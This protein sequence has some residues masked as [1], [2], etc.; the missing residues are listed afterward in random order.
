MAISLQQTLADHEIR[1]RGIEQR[2]AVFDLIIEDHAELEARVIAIE[3]R[4][5]LRTSNPNDNWTPETV[6]AVRPTP[7]PNAAQAFIEDVAARRAARRNPMAPHR[8]VD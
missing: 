2:E 6:V 8:T 5:G 7:Q 1:I 4:L 3:Q